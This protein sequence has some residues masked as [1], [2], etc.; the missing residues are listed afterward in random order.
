MVE[1]YCGYFA[2]HFECIFTNDL[3]VSYDVIFISIVNFLKACFANFGHSLCSLCCCILAPLALTFCDSKTLCLFCLFISSKKV[4]MHFVHSLCSLCSC[5]LLGSLL[6]I[7][8]K[9]TRNKREM[10]SFA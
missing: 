5:I 9:K 3:C 7:K 6:N 8:R 2:L 4:F 10:F 1:A